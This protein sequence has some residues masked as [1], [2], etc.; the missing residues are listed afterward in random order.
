MLQRLTLERDRL[1]AE[2]EA[3]RREI[4]GL[5]AQI[6]Q[7]AADREREAALDRDAVR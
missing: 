1:D 3:A 5:E 6:A 7:L 4:A 2:A